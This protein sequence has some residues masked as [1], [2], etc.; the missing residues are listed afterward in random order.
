MNG[1]TIAVLVVA[2]AASW[3]RDDAQAQGLETDVRTSR[4]EVERAAAL[5]HDRDASHRE[6]ALGRAR[7]LAPFD[8]VWGLEP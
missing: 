3:L 2:L 4:A 7:R 6:V 8:L 1:R 5:D